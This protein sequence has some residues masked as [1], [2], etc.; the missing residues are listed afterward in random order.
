M[1]PK[2][3][4]EACEKHSVFIPQSYYPLKGFHNLIKAFAKLAERY[5]DI[6]IYTTGN[7]GN[8]GGFFANLK[9]QT[10]YQKY[11]I[12]LINKYSLQKK[13]VFLGDLSAE[14][15]RDRLLKSNVFVLSSS[16]ENSPNSLGEAMILGVP[17]ICSDVGGVRSLIKDRQEGFL[18]PFDKP[19]MVEKYIV[20]VFSDIDTANLISKNAIKRAEI[21]HS[22]KINANALND[23]YLSFYR[24]YKAP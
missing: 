15:M 1:Q 22:T 18:Y 11:L 17:C 19:Q 6:H 16:L 14:Q 7:G 12:K 2:W 3:N 13:I 21:T 23:I 24:G 20:N 10:Y 9:H 4:Y 8:H 5:P